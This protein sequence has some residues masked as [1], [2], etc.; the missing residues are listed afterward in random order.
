MEGFLYAVNAETGKLVWEKKLNVGGLPALVEGIVSANGIVYAGT[1]KG[2]CAFDAATGNILWTNTG[3][4]Q[5]EG[6]TNTLS[7]G[8]NVLVNGV[9][10]GALYANDAAT[11]KM[12]W[13]N[14]KSGLSDR[15]ASAAIHGNRI[16]IISRAS[17]F[18]L[19]AQTGDIIVRKELPYSVDVTSTP[20]VTDSEII[21]G[22]TANGLTALHKE[23]LEPKWNYKTQAALTFTGPYTRYPAATIETSPVLSGQT[24]FFAA[25]DGGIY[26]LNKNDG[27]LIWQHQTGSPVFSTL[28]VSGNALFVTDFA[29]NVYCFGEES[30]R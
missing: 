19:D 23:T 16:Y 27:Q 15:G 24:V 12:L 4:N 1:G 6:S 9:Q 26:G 29:G 20:L 18:I 7:L 10:W 14:S 3:W 22:T 5:R 13:S 25:S 21:F 11:G 17:L 2:L 28:A 8:N 30:P